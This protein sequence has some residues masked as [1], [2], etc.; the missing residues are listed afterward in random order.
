MQAAFTETQDALREAV[1]D[2]LGDHAT[3]ERVR[4]VALDGDGFDGELWS[5]LVAMGVTDLPGAVEEGIV[6]EEL[7]RV[8]APVPYV[9]HVVA[10]A[11]ARAVAADD[12]LV[13]TLADGDAIGVFAVSDVLRL[14]DGAV[15]GTLQRVPHGLAATTLLALADDGQRLVLVA[16]DA[17][18]T[19]R[20][21]LSTMDRT[22]PL[23]DVAVDCAA[24]VIG[25]VDGNTII[26]GVTATLYAH[27]LIGVGQACLDMGVAYASERE[28]FGRGLR[29]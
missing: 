8:A 16:I 26:D 15:H 9:E 24:D 11:A 19:S 3:S 7:G 10:L 4:A 29:A 22:R 28:Q 12:D 13:G 6:A 20:T 18:A 2:L 17:D 1:T 5:R 27:D 14:D 25:S 23:A 21:A